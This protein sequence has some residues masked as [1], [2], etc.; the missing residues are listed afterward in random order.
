MSRLRSPVVRAGRARLG[1]RLH[2][3]VFVLLAL[4]PG[5]SSPLRGDPEGARVRHGTAGFSREG[6]VTRITTSDQAIIDYRSFDVRAGETVQFIQPAATSRVLNRITNQLP[7]HIDGIVKANGSVYFANPS[8]IFFGDRA[9]VDVGRLYAAAGHI[10][11]A[12]FL[13]GRDHFTSLS[14]PV[15]QHGTIRAGSV[16]LAGTRVANLGLIEATRVV[17]FQVG[18]DVYIGEADGRTLVRVSGAPAVNS[19]EDEPRAAV[20]NPGTV[21]VPGGRVL[22]GAGDLESLAFR[23]TG[24][25]EAAEVDIRAP[26][27]RVEIEG[28]IR[29]GSNAPAT[30]GGEI[31]VVG[32]EVEVGEATLDVSG[33]AGGGRIRLGGAREGGDELPGS[34]QTVISGDARLLADAT[35]EGDGG[36]V[37]VW[38][39]GETLFAGEI[40]ARG[41]PAGGNGGFVETSGFE[42]L[43]STGSVVASAVAGTGGVW[44]LDPSDI[45]IQSA[46]TAQGSFSGGAPDVFTPTGAGT[47][48]VDVADINA[49]L[50]SGTSVTI[51]TNSAGLQSGDVTFVAG[52]GNAISK[53]SGSDAT[54]RVDAAG[55]IIIHSTI[56]ST[57]GRLHL[58]FNNYSD[59]TISST[60]SI[61]TNGGNITWDSGSNGTFSSSGPIATGGGSLT[62][63]HGTGDLSILQGVSTAGG[64]VF[65]TGGSFLNSTAGTVAT[66]GGAFSLTVSGSG[67]VNFQ[68]AIDLTGGSGGFSIG[69]SAGTISLSAD[70]TGGGG[71]IQFGDNPVLL[72]EDSTILNTGAGAVTFGSLVNGDGGSDV[73]TVNAGSG[74]V[75]FGGN[76][77]PSIGLGTLAVT[78]T[79]DVVFSGTI[80]GNSQAT[81]VSLSGGLN[82]ITFGSAIGAG[83]AIGSLNAAA[84]SITL[85]NVGGA[86]GGVNGNLVLDAD[87]GIVF[88][89]TIYNGNQQSYTSSSG[90][91]RIDAGSPVTFS[92]SGDSI[93]FGGGRVQ[94]S[95]GANLT[96]QTAG[97]DVSVSSLEGT[98]DE[99]LVISAGTGAV[100]LGTTGTV[101]SGGIQDVT[102]TGSTIALG[103]DITTS[104]QSGGAN[105][106]D[107]T[108]T[109]AVSLGT[110]LT[111][112][113]QDDT[114]GDGSIT[115]AGTVDGGQDLV[116]DAGDGGDL[117]VSGVTGGLTAP[118]SLT[119]EDANSTT[120]QSALTLGGDLIQLDGT[121]TTDFQ[122]GV[123]TPGTIQLDATEIDFQ[124]GANSVSGATLVLRPGGATSIRLGDTGDTSAQILDL[125]D[126]DITALAGGFSSITI[127]RTGAG[128]VHPIVVDSSGARFGDSL[129]LHVAGIGASLTVSGQLDTLADG[130]T[131]SITVNGGGGTAV[132]ADVVTSGGTITIDDVLTVS[133]T[134]VDIDTSNGAVTGADILVTGSIQGVVAANDLAVN[135]GTQGDATLA[136]DGATVNSIGSSQSL[137]SLTVDGLNLRLG[138]VGAAGG[139]SEGVTGMTDVDAGNILTLE[140]T[141]YNTAGAQQWEAGVG[142]IQLVGGSTTT[143]RTTADAVTFRSDVNLANSTDLVI[144]TLATGP[145]A[146]TVIFLGTIE[147]TSDETVSI[148][149]HDGASGYGDVTLGSVGGGAGILSISVTGDTLTLNGNLLTSTTDSLSNAITLEADTSIVL[150]ASLAAVAGQGGISWTGPV[151]AGSSS[152]PGV[153]L[154]AAGSATRGPVTID[155]AVGLTSPVDY[156]RVIAADATLGR[157]NLGD[158]QSHSASPG[159]ALVV[160]TSGATGLTL[161]G[162]VAT[163][164]DTLNPGVDGG[165]QISGS[166]LLDPRAGQVAENDVI[167]LELGDGVGTDPGLTFTGTLDVATSRATSLGIEA[168]NGDVDLS[169]ATL[170]GLDGLVIEGA[171]AVTLPDL[172]LGD[173]ATQA[174]QEALDVTATGVVTLR[175][176]VDTTGEGSGNTAGSIRVT[177]A[178][179]L[180]L[181]PASG[182]SITLETDIDG[183]GTDGDITLDTTVEATSF[184]DLDLLAGTGGDVDLEESLGASSSLGALVIEGDDVDL[185]GSIQATSITVTGHGSIEV[186]STG[187][188]SL[189]L[190]TTG[191]DLVF[192]GVLFDA[193]ATATFTSTGTSLTDEVYLLPSSGG[194]SIGL[195]DDAAAVSTVDISED[196]LRAID[197]SFTEVVIG[198]AGA[199]QTGAITVDD[200]DGLTGLQT[201]LRLRAGGASVVL[202]SDLRLAGT[203]SGF[204]I[205][206]GGAG[207]STQTTLTVETDGGDV[208][209][210][211]DLTV[212]SSSQLTLD[213]GAGGGDVSLT[214]DLRDFGTGDLVIEA[215]TGDVSLGDATTDEIGDSTAVNRFGQIEV[216][217]TGDLQIQGSVFAESLV[218]SGAGGDVSLLSSV[219][220][221]GV[222]DAAPGLALSLEGDA[223]TLADAADLTVSTGGGGVELT[224][225][226]AGTVVL[227][228]GGS[229]LSASP[230]ADF[231]IDENFT[232]IQLGGDIETRAGAIDLGSA[233]LL[234]ADVT[235]D[236]TVGD[237]GGADIDLVSVD[238]GASTGALT[239]DAG[240]TGDITVSGTLGQGRA[241]GGLTI[242]DARD[243]SLAGVQTDLGL[244]SSSDTFTSTGAIESSGAGVSI[245]AS[246]TSGTAIQL[247]AVDSNSQSVTLTSSDDIL[248]T[249]TVESSTGGGT[250]TIR[251]PSVT[252]PIALG[253]GAGSAAG[254]GNGVHLDDDSV[255][256]L[257][258]G[259]TTGGRVIG[260]AG[261][262]GAIDLAG[263]AQVTGDALTLHAG[264]GADVTIETTLATTD[265]AGRDIT[266][267]GGGSS[268]IRLEGDLRTDGGAIAITGGGDLDV[269]AGAVRTLDTATT[270][271]TAG[272]VDLSAVSISSSESGARLA[273][274][275]SAVQQGGTV[276]LDEVGNASGEALRTLEVTGTGGTGSGTLV[277]TD[278]ITLEGTGA[279][280]EAALTVTGSDITIAGDLTI[281]T[282][283][284]GDLDAGAIDLGEGV[285]SGS[286]VGQSLTLDASYTGISTRTGGDLRLGSVSDGSSGE[287]LEAITLDAGSVTSTDGTITLGGDLLVH[288]ASSSAIA[289]TGDLVADRDLTLDTNQSTGLA[290]GGVDLADA[291]LSASTSGVDLTVD[292]STADGADGGD[293]EIGSVEGATR[294]ESLTVVSTSGG[295]GSDG[296][297]TLGVAAGS[298]AIE[299]E[300]HVDLSGTGAILLAGNLSIDTEPDGSGVRDGSVLFDPRGSIDGSGSLTITTTDATSGGGSDGDI[301]LP[302]SMGESTR[303]GAVS[304]SSD[305]GEI[306]TGN[307][308]P[309]GAD[310]ATLLADSITISGEVHLEADTLLETDGGLLDVGGATFGAEA[311]DRDLELRTTPSAAGAGGALRLGELGAPSSAF[312]VNDLVLDTRA[313]TA[314]GAGAVTL[315]GDISLDDDGSG[316]TGS[317]GVEGSPEIIVGGRITID[318]EAGATAAG[319][320]IDLGS[321]EI[322]AETGGLGLTLDA[323]GNGTGGAITTGIVDTG[324]DA[325]LSHFEA[326][327]EGSGT[328]TLPAS[329]RVDA[330]TSA[331][332]G[333]VLVGRVRTPLVATLDSEQ[334]GDSDAGIID[335]SQATLAAS[336]ADSDLLLDASTA[337]SRDGGAIALGEVDD[338]GG[339]AS[340]IR[341]LDLDTSTSSGQTGEMTLHDSILLDTSGAGA[342]AGLTIQG[343]GVI[344]ITDSLSL[345]T[346]QGGTN[347]G[348]DID[349]GASTITSDGAAAHLL[350]LDARGNG[351]GGDVELGSLGEA[352]GGS[353]PG[354]L[355]VLTEGT[356]EIHLS[357]DLEVDDPA[358]AL[359]GAGVE[360]I[361]TVVVDESLVVDTA[362]GATPTGGAIDLDQA[363]ISAGATGRSLTLDASGA[364]TGGAVR[365]STVDD[366]AGGAALRELGIDTRAGTTAGAVTLTGDL[367]LGDGGGATAS[368]LEI[369]GPSEIVFEGSR[370]VDLSTSTVGTAAG[371]FDPGGATLVASAPGET[372]TI[373]VDHLDASGTGGSIDG[374]G[375]ITEGSGSHFDAVVLRAGGGASGA[376]GSISFTGS[377]PAIEVAGTS[378]GDADLAGIT[379]EG[380]VHIPAGSLELTTNPD[381]AAAATRAIDLGAASV[382][383]PGSLVLDT[384]GSGAA[385]VAGNITLGD[386]G[387]TTPLGSLTADTRGATSDG[388][389]TLAGSRVATDGG[390]ID[391]EDADQIRLAAGVSVTLDTESGGDEAAGSVWLTDATHS[392]G[393]TVR[394]QVSGNEELIIQTR[395][396]AGDGAVRLGAAGTLATPLGGLAISAGTAAVDLFDDVVTASGGLASL[397]GVQ[398]YQGTVTLRSDLTLSGSTTGFSGTLDGARDLGISGDAHFQGT[399]G[400]TTPLDSLTVTGSTT[401]EAA[402]TRTSPTITVTGDLILGEDAAAD[403]VTLAETTV[404]AADA[405][406]FQASLSGAEDLVVVA[407][408]ALTFG[409]DVGA[410]ASSLVPLGDGSGASITIDSAT[411]ILFAGEVELASGLQQEAGAGTVTFREDVTVLDGDT[412]SSFAG[413]VVLDG[414]T[415]ETA[416]SVTFGDSTVDVLTVS[417]DSTIFATTIDGDL[418]FRGPIEGPGGLL[419]HGEGGVVEFRRPLGGATPLGHFTLES[420]TL[421]ALDHSIT[422]TGDIS[423]TRPGVVEIPTLATITR[424]VGDVLLS[425]SAGSITLGAFHKLT[426]LGDITLL[427]PAGTVRLEGDLTSG[428]R[429]TVSALAIELVARAPGWVR[430][431][432]PGVV[433]QDAGLDFVASEGMAFSVVPVQV[434]PGTILFASTEGD[435]DLSGTLEAFDVVTFGFAIDAGNLIGRDGAVLDLRAQGPQNVDVSQALAGVVGSRLSLPE[436]DGHLLALAGGESTAGEG[437]VVRRVSVSERLGELEGVTLYLDHLPVDARVPGVLQVGAGRMAPAAAGRLSRR[438]EALFG[439]RSGG[440][441][442][443]GRAR[444]RLNFQESVES[445][446]RSTPEAGIDPTR[447]GQFMRERHPD[448]A[449]AA[450]DLL[451]LVEDLEVSA[452]LT[453]IESHELR[454]DLLGP[455]RP[456]GMTIE[457]FVRVLEVASR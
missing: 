174:G 389:L 408:G 53:A 99:S 421:L 348:G 351:T 118:T 137:D 142:E 373:L 214:G 346:E 155:G 189:V 1:L 260:R 227:G 317:I 248:L 294:L 398:S 427:A 110:D 277:L 429:I 215:G 130:D 446:L 195:G 193:D 126:T 190:D 162:D 89:G 41:G 188:S 396:L 349:L 253:T 58:D 117:V 364:T 194:Q 265:T 423:F 435:G 159:M 163:T 441:V 314:G 203:G 208:A 405:I 200:T 384:S 377:T 146:G 122:G 305:T 204:T 177:G 273:L 60:G 451:G 112:R 218:K 103:G 2:L 64:G 244:D 378:G 46:A 315:E 334:G 412:Q 341:Q 359:G 184:E 29:A 43:V 151:E 401:L 442:R 20:E 102:V 140:G 71:A 38:S 302:G 45:L 338:D 17:T 439:A 115:I 92:S 98:T 399:V 320:A 96:I 187:G 16:H 381:G 403:R 356:G 134:G 93:S 345:D 326:R 37:I 394:G 443:A 90:I 69:D 84:D 375:S 164:A 123:T 207:T 404:L 182:S 365:L 67:S 39:D 241:V 358:G 422:T 309:G 433:N 80:D 209:I 205:E 221:N 411:S 313:N 56:E 13:A 413:D 143:F 21:R 220:L 402:G 262:T 226:G 354:A 85:V 371:D 171:S 185:D 7:T 288:G 342:A 333:I 156:L 144:T 59:L 431:A 343:D 352:A 86:S 70:I 47:A 222:A 24:E 87:D 201:A 395:S 54:L 264:G 32:R 196:L 301:Q 199:A 457:A 296:T 125:T 169:G 434:G 274:D 191:G 192:T 295:A 165:V 453:T 128:G 271:T 121:T 172:L 12:D 347:A 4:I 76:V 238:G 440:S 235:L 376:D 353:R 239:L 406:D 393:A 272:D 30:T 150:G 280:S 225:T 175:G 357:G 224:G 363:T 9:V 374:L 387:T 249:G 180:V 424:R 327:T 57:T 33:E 268:V 229:D 119:I 26:E 289:I 331:T 370:T 152:L 386:A 101:V 153:T 450:R 437:L 321:G 228:A 14:G 350:T 179:S 50:N 392:G 287:F 108:L 418:V 285:I 242:S 10:S 300:D 332:D 419:V 223:I 186:D 18:E 297:V 233:A 428:G 284:S 438:F 292:T 219:D 420:A 372:L 5:P 257:G 51:T 22:I 217:T 255:A 390:D 170:T 107:I 269:A 178:S 23:Q 426:S 344:R 259:F 106:G 383:G 52:A 409:G 147:G 158:G 35:R 15:I 183:G 455:L 311:R 81:A 166:L 202:G 414:L 95:D 430:G 65:L 306:R 167:R 263:A 19:P 448:V 62:V 176:N 213:T 131:G 362:T 410:S 266:I 270:S 94:L 73:L 245:T 283:A 310:T 366:V 116:L 66:G 397:D 286:G 168:G 231:T 138:H 82:S 181:D 329:I 83:A 216:T 210:L 145:A 61:S 432:I 34:R 75:T 104:G 417:T 380:E 154:S 133:N 254:A 55:E 232:S 250:L 415:F 206:G 68:N 40:S 293:V 246:G 304:L 136:I 298:A 230:G 324:S 36:E 436:R 322:S 157:L 25:V 382:E 243:V 114:D 27:G 319:G 369:D 135:S 91:L 318:T 360:L 252:T 316:D 31:T 299:V 240:T 77:G 282:S 256:F 335:L 211:D 355:R 312:R 385:T 278:S 444:L 49:S 109:G 276:R 368:S 44:L 111:L 212:G 88:N 303:L 452:G 161:R 379:L 72:V 127:G 42:M 236:A 456:F 78:G 234:D 3:L 339:T 307:S 391:F 416:P 279:G 237:A 325:Y 48:T 160:D 291:T 361:G 281:T 367:T 28:S 105:P 449:A 261:Q 308:D 6:S 79:G 447:L 120:F 11:D 247:A 340:R 97:G 139:G 328:I 197:A 113:T 337:G 336:A 425:S 388:T 141:T 129:V 454:R 100:S 323:R 198:A 258:S 400:D 173:G 290:G 132:S 445:F 124:G 74:T 275:V 63:N 267:Q 407:S 251:G 148:T 330:P 8:G 149:A